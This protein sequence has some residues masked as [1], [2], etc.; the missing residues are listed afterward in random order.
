M[1]HPNVID[2]EIDINTERVPRDDPR[3]RVVSIDPGR[4]SGAPC[5]TGTR[6]PIQ[7]LWDHLS[8]NASLEEFLEDYPSVQREQAVEA[9]RLASERLL[10]GLILR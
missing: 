1:P 7:I 4:H 8:G 3:S 6:V 5:F 10:D 2:A 9:I